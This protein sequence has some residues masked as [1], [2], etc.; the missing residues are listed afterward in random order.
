MI[1]SSH[2]L[3]GQGRSMLD[4]SLV[5]GHLILSVAVPLCFAIDHPLH[6]FVSESQ[7]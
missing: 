4:S 7:S 2:G 6:F 1:A 5:V 3:V